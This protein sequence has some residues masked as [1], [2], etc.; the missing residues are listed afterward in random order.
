MVPTSNSRESPSSGQAKPWW[1]ASLM[2]TL[3]SRV[4]PGGAACTVMVLVSLPARQPQVAA[5]FLGLGVLPALAHFVEEGSG[6]FIKS[7]ELPFNPG[8]RSLWG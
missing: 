4:V 5:G 2:V 8:E 7:V 1:S 3:R 6:E